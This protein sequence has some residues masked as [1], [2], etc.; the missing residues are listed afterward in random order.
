MPRQ[1]IRA[2]PSWAR[3]GKTR[4]GT[5]RKAPSTTRVIEIPPPGERPT[6]PSGLACR[7]WRMCQRYS[8]SAPGVRR[9]STH[10]PTDR[11]RKAFN[12]LSHGADIGRIGSMNGLSRQPDRL[13]AAIHTS[14]RPPRLPSNRIGPASWC[15][16]PY[17]QPVHGNVFLRSPTT[18]PTTGP[19]ATVAAPL[20]SQTRVVLIR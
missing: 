1:R 11:Q 12:P 9:S 16:N 18:G 20:A 7:C 19:T 5:R 8:K 14:V 13:I 3:S 15:A 6:M 2:E 17:R 10:R 4:I